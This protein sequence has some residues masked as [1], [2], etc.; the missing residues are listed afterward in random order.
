MKQNELDQANADYNRMFE[1]NRNLKQRNE[2]LNQVKEANLRKVMDQYKTDTKDYRSKQTID[3][4]HVM[5]AMRE[6][7]A[8]KQEQERE[9]I[10]KIALAAINSVHINN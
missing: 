2:R 7:L 9:I 8:F 6:F 3:K 4:T 10:S 5:E 1:L